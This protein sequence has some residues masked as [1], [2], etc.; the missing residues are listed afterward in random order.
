MLHM[1]CQMCSF[2]IVHVQFVNFI[3]KPDPNLT[4]ILTN[5]TPILS[6]CTGWQIVQKTASRLLFICMESLIFP[7][8]SKDK[9][10][11]ERVQHCF[12]HY[13]SGSQK[14]TTWTLQRLSHL[15]LWTLWE[16]CSRA[17]ISVTPRSFFFSRLEDNTTRVHNMKLKKPLSHKSL[18]P[19]L[20][21][22]NCQPLEQL[23]TEDI[24]GTMLNSFNSRL[25]RRRNH[26]M[27]FFQTNTL[28]NPIGCTTLYQHEE[29]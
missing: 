28:L 2:E 20:L 29:D 25:L 23:I 21:S 5:E 24:D 26:E 16:R 3:P 13:V 19:L 11:L 6:S 15:H 18:T 27:D 7:Y 12:T 17:E 1:I 8:L 10:L 22:T 9:L 4:L 14:V